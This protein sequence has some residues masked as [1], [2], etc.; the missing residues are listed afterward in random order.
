MKR[1]LVFQ[2]NDQ[3]YVCVENG[4]SIFEIDKTDLKF[5][6]EKFYYSFFSEGN[7]FSEIELRKDEN[8][9][10]NGDY[11]YSCIT[12]LLQEIISRLK[13]ELAKIEVSEKANEI[14]AN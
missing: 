14:D 12:N 8:L 7:D 2:S 13:E 5:D 6:V 1:T 4:V 11:I 10:K 3:K 9:D